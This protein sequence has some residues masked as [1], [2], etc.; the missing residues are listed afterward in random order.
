MGGDNDVSCWMREKEER[1]GEVRDRGVD[2]VVV[3]ME[4]ERETISGEREVWWR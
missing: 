2:V 1:E 3:A 4:K